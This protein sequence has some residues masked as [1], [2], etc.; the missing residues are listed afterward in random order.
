MPM[1]ATSRAQQRA[2]DE[3]T[4]PP[5]EQLRP[6]TW[7]IPV[8]M[9][10]P[11]IPY[12]LCYVLADDVGDVHL[13][14][15]GWATKEA[16]EG[17]LGGLDAIG[18]SPDAVRTVT[19]THA[20]KDHIGLSKR[21]RNEV[22]ATLILGDVETDSLTYMSSPIPLDLRRAPIERWGVPADHRAE[23]EELGASAR[24]DDKVAVDMR[25]ADRAVLPIPGRE[26]R[27]L[28]TPGHTHGHLCFADD[29]NQLL[30]TGDHVLPTM[31]PGVGL[32]GPGDDNPLLRYHRSLDLVGEFDGF[33]ACPGHGYRF[34]GLDVRRVEI[35]GHIDR[36]AD[37]VAE[38]LGRSPQASVWD[39][40]RTLSWSE[41]WNNLKGFRLKSAL[42]QTEIYIA[43]VSGVPVAGLGI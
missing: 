12:V 13:I 28:L 37:E 42:N 39:I 34:R 27:V 9:P 31:N 22:G 2:W 19:V 33:E 32:G 43:L 41:G 5:A 25:I 36:R 18:A 17:L 6:D 23:L 15:P 10:N 16:W 11:H 29:A 38:V 35:R 7:A 30:F 20:H 21:L 24:L 14:D 40:A 3:G 4:V 8:P 26:V 1:E